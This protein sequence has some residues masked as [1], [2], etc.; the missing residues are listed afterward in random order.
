MP[1]DFRDRTKAFAVRI[2]KMVDTLPRTR[3]ADVLGRQILRSGTS[4]GANYRSARRARSDAEFL[5]KLGI[6]EE[7]AD[8]TGYWLEL[9][10]EAG[11][12]RATRLQALIRECDEITA[13]TVASIKN[14]KRKR[15]PART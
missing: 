6:V 15:K 13:I 14:A 4:I 9:L 11:V 10:G 3:A 1:Q 7:E 2:I 8:E 12:V 5:S